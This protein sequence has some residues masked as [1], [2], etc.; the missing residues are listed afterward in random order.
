MLDTEPIIPDAA[1]DL[2]GWFWELDGGRQSGMSQNPL[3]WSEI[4]SWGR[5][6]RIK[7]APWELT[8]IKAMDRAYLGVAA[9]MSQEK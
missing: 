4:E 3:L 6:M 5:L 9:E 8:V 2:W 1:L 7:P